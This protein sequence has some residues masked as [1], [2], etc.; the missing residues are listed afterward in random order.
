MSSTALAINHADTIEAM[1]DTGAIWAL[2]LSDCTTEQRADLIDHHARVMRLLRQ[3]GHR[4]RAGMVNDEY[5]RE[6]IT[7]RIVT[8]PTWRVPGDH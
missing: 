6:T 5:D 4:V 7:L 8:G 1:C 2:I 3:R